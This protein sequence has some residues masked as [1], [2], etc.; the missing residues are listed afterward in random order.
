VA[1][2]PVTRARFL[3]LR[4][5]SKNDAF[6]MCDRWLTSDL[7]PDFIEDRRIGRCTDCAVASGAYLLPAAGFFFAVAGGLRPQAAASRLANLKRVRPPAFE[8]RQP[9]NV[10]DEVLQSRS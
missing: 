5:P 2:V 1:S 6:S 4:G 7:V 8:R 3:V 10:V 9:A